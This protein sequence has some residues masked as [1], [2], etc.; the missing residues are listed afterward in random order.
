[1]AKDCRIAAELLQTAPLLLSSTK[2][3][4]DFAAQ[5]GEDADYTCV[6]KSIESAA[7]E[8]IRKKGA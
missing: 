6:V 4:Q 7:G 2:M 5:H 3:V 1:M 8:E